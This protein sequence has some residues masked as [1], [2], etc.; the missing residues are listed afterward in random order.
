MGT[1]RATTL[2]A[3]TVEYEV[4]GTLDG[5]TPAPVVEIDQTEPGA[6]PFDR[7]AQIY[8]PPPVQNLGLIDPDLIGGGSIGPRCI[9]FVTID[10]DATGGSGAALDLV[11]VRSGSLSD[12]V[13]QRQIADLDGASGPI[14]LDEGFNV[15][16]GSDIRLSGFDAGGGEPIRVRVSLLVPRSC[17]DLAA[18][19]PE[20]G[21]VV[22]ETQT[23][24]A[25]P[26]LKEVFSFALPLN[27]VA[28]VDWK[29]VGTGFP[30]FGPGLATLASSTGR[31]QFF[32]DGT[33]AVF[34]VSPFSS[35]AVLGFATIS[36]PSFNPLTERVE[37]AVGN[38]VGG[39]VLNWKTTFELLRQ[40]T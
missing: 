14:F 22:I 30:G 28:V 32:R 19:K 10:T 31:S 23:T 20:P 21:S 24:E 11:A 37:Y 39:Q 38:G 1:E 34:S 27:S 4:L 26:A 35:T 7:D 36:G 3:I 16:Q 2:Q 13:F 40:T 17:L 6:T 25:P 9:P 15:P 12:V 5:T 18:F 29:T 8:T 33:G